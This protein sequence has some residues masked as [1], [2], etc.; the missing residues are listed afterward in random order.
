MPDYLGIA[1]LVR[2]DFSPQWAV[3]VI[4][5]GDFTRGFAAGPGYFKWQPGRSPPV[6][7]VPEINRS[8]LSKWM[9][10]RRH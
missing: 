4:T 9:R 2:R 7:L 3:F 10:T 5:L 6:K 8:D 1:P